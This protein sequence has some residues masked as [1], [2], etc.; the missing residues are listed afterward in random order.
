MKP[1]PPPPPAG[2]E[3][4]VAVAVEL[5]TLDCVGDVGLFLLAAAMIA[6]VLVDL[7]LVLAG[8]VVVVGAV[9]EFEVVDDEDESS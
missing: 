6:A 2:F 9:F 7:E 4:L 1:A 3:A 5:V 8:V